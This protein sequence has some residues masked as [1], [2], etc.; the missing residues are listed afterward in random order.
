MSK[1]GFSDRQGL[2]LEQELVLRLITRKVG[3]VPQDL[4]SSVELL[5]IDRLEV[6]AEALIDFNSLRDLQDW[7]RIN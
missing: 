2:Q 1:E 4:R 6:L 5:S 7:L 3:E